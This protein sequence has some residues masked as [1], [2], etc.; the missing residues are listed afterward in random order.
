MPEPSQISMQIDSII[1]RRKDKAEKMRSRK[2]D[3]QEL[4]KILNGCSQLAGRTN[5]IEDPGMREQCKQIFSKLVIPHEV[6]QQFNALIRRMDEAV[7]RFERNS[8]N[9]ATVGRAR[10]GKSTFLQAVGNLKDDIIPAYDAGDCT[11]AVSIIRNDPSIQ[12]GQVR[13]DLTFRSKEE[14][15]EIVKGYINNIDP[16]YLASYP[17]EYD[18]ISDINIYELGSRI[19]SGDSAKT[20]QL[21]HLRRI[22]DDFNENSDSKSLPIKSLCGEAG[23]SLTD[24][25]EIRKYVAQNNGRSIEDPDRENYYSYLAVKQ[26]TI[27]CRFS[28]DVGKL[29]LVDTIGL[30]DTQFGIEGAMLETVDKQCDA[31]IVVTKPDSGIKD[32]DQKLY[33]LLRNRFAKRDTRKWLFY[34]ANEQPGYNSNAVDTFVRH[35]KEK[36]FAVA[37]CLKINCKDQDSVRNDFLMP[38]LTT[39]VSNIEEIDAA[40]IGEID[41]MCAD[42]QRMLTNVITSFPNPDSIG[43]GTGSGWVKEAHKLGK[44]CYARMTSD[45]AKQVGYWYEQRNKPNAT[46]W[47]RVTDILDNLESILPSAEDLQRVLDESGTIIGADLWQTPLNYV[48]NEV[49]D[50]FILIDGLM[51]RETLEFKNSIVHELY[52]SLKNLSGGTG[53]EAQSEEDGN[54][55]KEIDQLQWL[56]GVMEP[57]LKDKP[58]YSQIYKAFQFLNKFEFNVRAQLIQEVRKQLR[59]INPMTTEYYMQPN[60]VFSKSNVG[61]AVHFYLTSRLAILE[62]GLRH[63]IGEMN[64]MPNQA[65]YAAAEEFYDRLTFASDFKN[66]KFVDM[67]EVWG[68][69]F[70]EYSNLLWAAE[71]ERHRSVDAI[72]DEYKQYNSTLKEKLSLIA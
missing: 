21:E 6:T 28:D 47:N 20:I 39:L 62:D 68:E 13:V 67:S 64:K 50:Q 27:N 12:I 58:E 57:M 46:M 49:T 38:M 33:D 16:E 37:D 4:R 23:R 55:D 54:D 42:L 61:Q 43:I 56:W 2:A 53:G 45:L 18:T 10:Q 14:L 5:T 9:V 30:G 25:N 40:Y 51:E 29:V 71:E 31:A 41:A 11:G 15:L 24:P 1:M 63:S 26:A 48:R 72:K 59:I 65:F 34:L 22:V 69:F 32:Q 35:V 66:G 52:E 19:E 70:T 17:V 44:V 36:N 60:Y 3:I 8:L 7:M